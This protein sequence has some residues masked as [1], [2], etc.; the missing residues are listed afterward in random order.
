MRKVLLFMHTSLDGFVGGP[1]GEMDWINV[2]D[3]IFDY[4]GNRTDE[5]D[6]ALY[7]RV[8]YQMMEGYWPTAANQP[9]AT[10]HDIQHSTWYN[11]VDKVVLSRTMKGQSLKKTTVLSDNIKSEINALKQKKGKDIIMFGS[12][13]A[14]HSLMEHDLID[15]FW[16]FVNPVLLGKGIPLFASIE[17]IRKLKLAS[18]HTFPSGVVCLYYTKKSG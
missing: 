17:D 13:T 1:N 16:L 7:G 3:A 10:K 12:P 4:A 11:S 8:T 15:D 14:A 5:A 2:D 6:T 9:G 18:S